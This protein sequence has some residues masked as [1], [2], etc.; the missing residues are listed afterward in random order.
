M[1]QRITSSPWPRAFVE[2]LDKLGE[3]ESGRLLVEI[4][5]ADDAADRDAAELKKTL[6]GMMVLGLVAQVG[7]VP[8]RPDGPAVA[9]KVSLSGKEAV[10]Q[11]AS[12]DGDAERWVPFGKF[13][14]KLARTGEKIDSWRFADGLAE[15]VLTRSGSRAIA[16]R[17]HARERQA[18]LSAP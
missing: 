16:Q 6:R 13:S 18:G 2:G 7:Q 3:G 1:G 8:A 5:G 9:C 17:F 14:L 15:G 11:I 10:V 12:S 4:S